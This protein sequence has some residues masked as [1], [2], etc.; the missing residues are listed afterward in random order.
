MARG[1]KGMDMAGRR[2]GRS[3]DRV[4]EGCRK[5]RG[6]SKEVEEVEGGEG[7]DRA[8]WVELALRNGRS[9]SSYG[10]RVALDA[11]IAMFMG[12]SGLQDG[13]SDRRQGLNEG[14]KSSDCKSSALACEKP[15]R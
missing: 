14:G 11:L 7:E 6:K 8:S 13:M 9:R 4:G 10:T 2:E 15:V 12:V 1:G 3:A 5:G